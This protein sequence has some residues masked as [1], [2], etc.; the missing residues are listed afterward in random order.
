MGRLVPLLS[1]AASATTLFLGW[2]KIKAWKQEERK[3][4]GPDQDGRDP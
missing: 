2:I 4:K 3:R 1:V